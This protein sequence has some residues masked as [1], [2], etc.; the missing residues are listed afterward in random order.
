MR[1]DLLVCPICKGALEKQPGALVCH[2]CSETYR[3]DGEIPC[4]S[5]TDPFYDEYA[6]EHCPYALSPSGLKG[7]ILRFLP[8]WSWREW[9]FWNSVIPQCE[10]L[11]DLGCGRGRELFAAKARE[12]V[13]FDGS[14][15]FIRDCATHYEVVAQ[16]TL[17][18]LPF[19]S[20]SFDAVVASHV[21]GHVPCSEKDALIAEVA[22]LMRPGAMCA[23]LIETDS[24]HPAVVG[25]KRK[26]ETYRRQFIEQHGHVGLE[27]AQQA[28]RRFEKQG[29]RLRRRLLVDAV[30]PSVLN[31]RTLFKHPDFD[32]VPALTWTRRFDRWTASHAIANLAY[33]VGMGTFHRTIEQWIGKP[34]YAQFALVQF[35]RS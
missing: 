10:R 18:H 24:N 6:S 7:L 8:F 29:F 1:F 30:L 35:V 3:L 22:R 17:P 34:S 32:D 15:R 13:G 25:A 21:L 4:F 19:Q 11:L 16:G 20:R 26:P 14:L 33:E 2:A 12:T 27:Y 5:P 28:I 31:F 23:F 9:K